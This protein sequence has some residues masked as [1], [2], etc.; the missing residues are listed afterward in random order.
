[1]LERLRLCTSAGVVIVGPLFAGSGVG[2]TP[3]IVR[4]QVTNTLATSFLSSLRSKF[5]LVVMVY[6]RVQPAGVKISLSLS[7]YAR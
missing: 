4:S 3:W 6:F 5:A 7:V 2:P 1:M